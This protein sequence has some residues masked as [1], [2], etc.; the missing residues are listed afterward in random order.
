M[1]IQTYTFYVRLYVLKYKIRNVLE[2]EWQLKSGYIK[3]TC[4]R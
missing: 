1:C 2:E 4:L 3:L